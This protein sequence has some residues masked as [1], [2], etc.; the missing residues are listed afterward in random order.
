MVWYGGRVAGWQGGWLAGWLGGRVA[1]HISQCAV[2]SRTGPSNV[3]FYRISAITAGLLPTAWLVCL[4]DSL[5]L[6]EFVFC[7]SSFYCT[8]AFCRTLCEQTANAFLSIDLSCIL[9]GNACLQSCCLP[10]PDRQSRS[11]IFWASIAH[12]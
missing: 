9:A 8:S 2:A 11:Q 10:L 4:F 6:S 1:A 3:S 7:G 5:S 12:L